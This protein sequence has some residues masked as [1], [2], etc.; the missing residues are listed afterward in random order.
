LSGLRTKGAAARVA[1]VVCTVSSFA[2]G[3]QEYGTSKRASAYDVGMTHNLQL[4]WI[5]PHTAHL[6]NHTGTVVF[7][8]VLKATGKITIGGEKNWSFTADKLPD[9]EFI[10][11]REIESQ[12][13]W[14]D[15]APR[16]EISWRDKDSQNDNFRRVSLIY[17]DR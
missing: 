4:D 10:G 1:S 15:D 5:D 9:G 14:V 8:V 11:I 16:L 13:G 3:P 6:A 2:N 12:L 7:D 17:R